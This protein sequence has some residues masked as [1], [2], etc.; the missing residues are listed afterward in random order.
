MPQIGKE[1]AH[2]PFGYSN[3]RPSSLKKHFL[4]LYLEWRR[5]EQ[6][7][8]LP[9]IWTAGWA[10]HPHVNNR[11]HEE[12]EHMWRWLNA[13]FINSALTFNPT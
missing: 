6:F 2:G 13:N 9:K 11:Y 1:G 8:D 3:C 12:I 10:S 5:A 4:M 7:G